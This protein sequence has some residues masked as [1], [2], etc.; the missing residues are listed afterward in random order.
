MPPDPLK[1]YT[2][3]TIICAYINTCAKLHSVLSC[4]V[5]QPE[6]WSVLLCHVYQP[7]CCSV[8][9]W[10]VYQPECTIVSKCISRSA[11]VCY[12]AL[13]IS[14]SV[15]VYYSVMCASESTGAIVTTTIFKIMLHAY[16]SA[17]G[18]EC[19]QQAIV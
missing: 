2:L 3:Y 4:Y 12:C 19:M 8:L 17:R 14:R 7:E 15:A 1:F 11:V 10:F 13:C 9:L 18:W 16:V 6:C 5:Y